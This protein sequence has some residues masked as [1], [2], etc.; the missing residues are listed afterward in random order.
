MIKNIDIKTDVSGKWV[1]ID[2]VKELIE[3]IVKE[4]A[5]IADVAEPYKANDLIKKH[6]GINE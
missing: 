1:S 5:S 2:Y 4:C 3:S 6:F